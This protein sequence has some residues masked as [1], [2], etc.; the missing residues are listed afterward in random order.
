MSIPSYTL[1]LVDH[2]EGQKV[3]DFHDIS[4]YLFQKHRWKRNNSF[5]SFKN[6]EVV[7]AD[8]LMGWEGKGKI[9]VQRAEPSSEWGHWC[10]SRLAVHESTGAFTAMVSQCCQ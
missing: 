9:Q 4:N 3:G 2:T 5:A 6:E 8:G 1:L 10:K 7:Y